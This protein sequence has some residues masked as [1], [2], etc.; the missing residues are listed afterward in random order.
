MY[1]KKFDIEE[2][3]EDLEKKFKSMDEGVAKR[4][5]SEIIAGEIDVLDRAIIVVKELEDSTYKF[6]ILTQLFEFREK[7]YSHLKMEEHLRK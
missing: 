6:K 5:V 2:F 3:M 1:M 7:C 4:G